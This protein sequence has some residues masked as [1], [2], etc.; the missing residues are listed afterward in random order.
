MSEDTGISLILF[1]SKLSIFTRI[2]T[3][4][5]LLQVRICNVFL[6]PNLYIYEGMF[7]MNIEQLLLDVH[8]KISVESFFQWVFNIYVQIHSSKLFFLAMNSHVSS[9]YSSKNYREKI[10]GMIYLSLEL[11]QGNVILCIFID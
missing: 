7:P 1:L 11:I 6:V 10:F 8:V 5:I 4:V 3:T 9:K 2:P